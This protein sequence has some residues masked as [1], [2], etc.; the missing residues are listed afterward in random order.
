MTTTLIYLLSAS[1]AALGIV[2][3]YAA[4]WAQV[5]DAFARVLR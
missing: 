5:A 3:L 2:L 4:V 1:A